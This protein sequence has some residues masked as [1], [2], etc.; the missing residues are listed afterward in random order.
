MNLKTKSNIFQKIFAENWNEY[1]IFDTINSN[2]LTYKNFFELV[3]NIKKNLEKRK[4]KEDD[5]LCL[6]LNNSIE[7]IALF[8][9]AALLKITLIC[10]DPSRGSDEILKMSTIQKS[11]FYLIDDKH[12]NFDIPETEIF[13]NIFQK[14]TNLNISIS[15]LDLFNDLNYE[16]LFTITFTSGSTGIPKG[17][18]HNLNNY[19]KSSLLFNKRFNF[20]KNNIFYHNLPLSYIGG[21]LNLL[22]LPFFS[23]SKIVL[24]EQFNISKVSNF[25]NN[26]VQYSVNTFW[27]TPTELS[28]LLKLDRGNLGIEY[29]KNKKIVGL[30]GTAS[31][32]EEIKTNFEKKYDVKLFESYCLSETFFVTTNYL[33]NDQANHTGPLLDDV[34]VSFTSDNEILLNTPSMFLGYLGLSN[35]E[36]FNNNGFY[37]SGDL[38]KL[39]NNSLQILGR[40]KDLI[41]KGGMN[42]S[43]KRIEDFIIGLK[44][45]DEVAI[46]GIEEYYMGEKIV[47]FYTSEEPN[48]NNEIKLINNQIVQKLG[49]YF[50]IDEFIKLKILPKTP[51][52]KIN[53]PTLKSKYNE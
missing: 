6:I 7:L 48:L 3:I 27:F 4:V 9:V 20:S 34:K 8:F 21:I 44:I 15:D 22:F 35:D 29:C 2:N 47:C 19:L 12:Q 51:S 23:K 36:F 17:V 33:N 14:N 28:L 49:L 43:P 45:F 24:D 32:R 31:L 1:F 41:I 13:S 38:G 26:P 10:I 11:K 52:G 42:I 30:V 5:Y 25:W 16:R 37:I 39:N 18:M 53:K 46:L 40:K 50:K